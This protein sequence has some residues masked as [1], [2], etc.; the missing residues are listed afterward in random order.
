[1][2]CSKQSA[3]NYIYG[4]GFPMEFKNVILLVDRRSDNGRFD[5]EEPTQI[6]LCTFLL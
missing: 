4:G 3:N 2:R 1:M 6:H 5:D